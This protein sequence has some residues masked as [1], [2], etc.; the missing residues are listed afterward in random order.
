MEQLVNIAE[1]RLASASSLIIIA[2]DYF[3]G[4]KKQ[5]ADSHSK[6]FE[7]NLQIFLKTFLKRKHHFIRKM[8]N[9]LEIVQR[10][11]LNLYKKLTNS[12][13]NYCTEMILNDILFNLTDDL[14]EKA[15]KEK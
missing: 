1:K 10:K 7:I 8:L 15:L 9:Q 2:D 13:Q 14:N 11:L 5:K 3:E 12:Y 4:V 6:V